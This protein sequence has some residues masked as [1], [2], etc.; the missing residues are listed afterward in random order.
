MD[1]EDSQKIVIPMNKIKIKRR[2]KSK[3][4]KNIIILN[5]ISFIQ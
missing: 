4:F 5:S 1:N 3:L 2:R